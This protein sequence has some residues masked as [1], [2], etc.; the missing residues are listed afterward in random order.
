M[1]TEILYVEL[2][3]TKGHHGPAWIGY[4]QFNKSRRTIYFNGK[5]FGKGKGIIGN[6][7]DIEQGDE[8]WISGVKKNGEDRHWAGSGK[9]QIDKSVINDYLQIIGEN[10]LLKSKFIVVDLNNIPNKELARNIENKKLTDDSF[11]SD[12]LRVDNLKKIKDEDI[13][14]IL[15]YYSRLDLTNSSEKTRMEYL[16][17]IDALTYELKQRNCNNVA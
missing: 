15:K 3:E 14:R 9:I 2:I 8:Y 10:T 1:K 13:T 17:K 12:L 4:G 5:V 11:N 6:H 7:F 16:N